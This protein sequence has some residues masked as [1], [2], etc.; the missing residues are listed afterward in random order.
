MLAIFSFSFLFCFF[1]LGCCCSFV[2]VE[3]FSKWKFYH[4]MLEES[5]LQ[6]LQP[7]L[8]IA[9]IETWEINSKKEDA[10]KKNLDR[11]GIT[12]RYHSSPFPLENFDLGPSPVCIGNYIF[13]KCKPGGEDRDP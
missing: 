2:N 6:Q 1:S 8:H 10:T 12:E 4:L 3:V 11:N 5:H 9:K 13:F 7:I